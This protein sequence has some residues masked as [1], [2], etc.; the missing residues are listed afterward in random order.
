M[1]PSG[2]TV[3]DSDLDLDTINQGINC[4]Q[5]L[6]RNKFASDG[7]SLNYHLNQQGLDSRAVEVEIYNQLTGETTKLYEEVNFTVNRTS[8][9]ITFFSV[10]PKDCL[11]YVLF[12]KTLSGLR[13]RILNCTIFTEFDNRFFASGNPD[14]P[15]AIF[16]CEEDDIEYFSEDNKLEVGMD[17][18]QVKTLIPG[19][20]V[21]WAVKETGQNQAGAYYL[22]PTI[23]SKYG[24]YYTPVSGN[25]TTGCVSTGINFNDDIVFFSKNGLEGF[26]SSAMYSEQVLGH[27][28]TYIDARLLSEKNYKNIK[29]CEYQGYLLALI[30]SN[31]YVADKRKRIN[32]G[33]GSTEYEWFYWE[34]PHNIT[35]ITEYQGQLYL[36]NNDGEL[37]TFT[38]DG[39][40]EV[41]S[42]WTTCEDTFGYPSYTKT[43]GKKV[44]KWYLK[45]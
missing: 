36:G 35:Y 39:E 9:I 15:Q 30:N 44:L 16:W 28:S 41:E 19:N 10:I 34:L 24:K 22:T 17:L 45:N 8:G 3:M 2:E 27:R 5:P 32:T 40:E 43:T 23:N 31:V 12:S 11:V 42:Y 25:I 26:N 18:A 4:L 1:T 21:L 13:N 6:Q 14:Y 38:Y 37:Y 7:E 29:L 33:S 20:N